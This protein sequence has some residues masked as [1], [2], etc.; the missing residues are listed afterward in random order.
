MS[1]WNSWGD[2]A[3]RLFVPLGGN[4]DNSNAPWWDLGGMIQGDQERTDAANQQRQKLLYDQAQ[5]AGAFAGQGQAS[6][7]NLGNQGTGALAALQARANGQSSVSAEQLRQGLQQNLAA[8]RSLA[9]GASS[10]DSA[11]AART[12][13]MQSARLGAGLAG[14]QAIAGLQ[15]R[16]QAQDQYGHLLGALRG[17]DLQAALGAR[18]TAIQGYG[19]NNAGTP[20]KSGLEKYG[21]TIASVAALAAS[22][23]RLK[24][25]VRDG[26]EDANKMLDGLRAWSYRYKDGERFGAGERTGVMAQDL[27]RAGIGH[28][29]V[30]TPEGKMVHGAHLS[31]ANTAMIAALHKRLAAVEGKAA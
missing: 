28:A 17:Q 11:M 5:Q 14:Q 29:V 4:V 15:E 1:F 21:P 24:D 12:A 9:A 3:Q 19:A 30:D 16:N 26:D 20:E 13:A 23:R 27:E 6:Y 25:D 22:D 10:R 31:T 8:Q 18:Q 7:T 2:T